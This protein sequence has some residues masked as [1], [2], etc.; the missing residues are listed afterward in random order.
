MKEYGEEV[1]FNEFE[2]DDL[3]SL[4]DLS[5][6]SGY[7]ISYDELVINYDDMVDEFNESIESSDMDWA[8]WD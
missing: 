1:D 7:P 6:N 2:T 4:L 3:S 8:I 5:D